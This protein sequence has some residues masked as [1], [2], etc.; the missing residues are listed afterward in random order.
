MIT[1]KPYVCPLCHRESKHQTN[2]H[3]EIYV[4]C[5]NCG[6]GVLYCK[7]DAA[8]IAKREAK[9]IH[10]VDLC[11]Y[12]FNLSDPVQHEAY[13]ALC[14]VLDKNGF[15]KF[16]SVNLAGGRFFD[17][18]KEIPWVTIYEPDTF[19]GQYITNYGRLHDW[20]EAIYP[21]LDIKEGYFLEKNKIK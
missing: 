20:Y 17:C 8:L 14:G 11:Y 9:R 1:E 16:T 21:N 3:G 18:I 4:R 13:A 19:E 5:I 10:G 15:E 12:K 7:T 6:S 2:H